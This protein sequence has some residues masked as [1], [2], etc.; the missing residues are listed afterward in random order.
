MTRPRN[1]LPYPPTP[2]VSWNEEPFDF[3]SEMAKLK[4]MTD[5][6]L[7]EYGRAYSKLAKLHSQESPRWHDLY[8]LEL[9]T[10]EYRTRQK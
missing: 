5:A 2:N 4:K 9:A 1:L 10:H 3:E 6:E 8:R 7:R